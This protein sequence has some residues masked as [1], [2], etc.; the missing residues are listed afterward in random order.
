MPQRIANGLD[1]IYKGAYNKFYIDEL[2][3]FVTKKIVFNLIGSPAAWIDTNI[4][5]GTV[6]LTASVTAS[7]S[8]TIKGIQSGR[9]QQYLLY[10]FGGVATL[11]LIFIYLI[12]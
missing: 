6:N 10:F 2:Y 12:K 1:G 5:N 8:E 3:I 11:A 9:L 4:I 7:V